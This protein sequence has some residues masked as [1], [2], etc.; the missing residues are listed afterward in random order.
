MVD[1]R[2]REYEFT[3]KD[4]AQLGALVNKHAGIVVTE[5]KF[6]MFYSRLVRRVRA[7]GLANFKDYCSYLHKNIAGEEFTHF[8]NAITTNLTSFFREDHHFEYLSN[9]VIPHLLRT[10]VSTHRIRFWSAGCSTGEEPYSLAMVLREAIPV[11]SD[12][13][14]KILATDIDSNV[15]NTAAEGRYKDERIA[16]LTEAR[17]RK[18]FLK[19]KGANEGVVAVHPSLRNMIQFNRLNLMDESWPMKGGFDVI[20]CRNVVIYF[21][22]PTKLRLIERYVNKLHSKGHLFI[23]HS[24]T[25]HQ[26]TDQLEPLGHTIYQKTF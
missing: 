22:A 4:F 12:W 23:G 13:D 14:V 20:F 19:G 8:I 16:G 9:T 7:L 11:E 24:E 5:E 1:H 2:K 26:L 18:W 15:L 10:N 3:R 21:D 6:D 25:I 17:K